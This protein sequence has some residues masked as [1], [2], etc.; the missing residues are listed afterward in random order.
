MKRTLLIGCILLLAF[1]IYY[2]FVQMGGGK[3][4]GKHSQGE[5]Q[6]PQT[7]TVGAKIF[8]ENC[9]SCHPSG[10]NVIEP[11]L[12]LKGSRAL[13][14]LNTFVAFIRN[15]KMPDGSQGYMPSFR[16][17][18]ISDKQAGELYHSVTSI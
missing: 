14:N 7:E 15:P 4:G 11:G 9:E 10:G 16:S 13:A 2:S 8:G 18:K 17:S 5:K 3:M 12:P 1:T 6:E